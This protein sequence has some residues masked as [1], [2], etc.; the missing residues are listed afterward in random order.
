MQ[1]DESEKKRIDFSGAVHEF[2]NMFL[3]WDKKT[4]GMDLQIKQVKGYEN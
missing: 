4:A 3:T 1:S 2:I